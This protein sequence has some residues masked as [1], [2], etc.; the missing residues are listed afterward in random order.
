M[1]QHRDAAQKAA[2]HRKLKFD[3]KMARVQNILESIQVITDL[4]CQ[5]S[6]LQQQC[7]SK[8]LNNC[9]KVS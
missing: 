4:A 5:L 6:F 1:Q 3:T 8:P 9:F 2:A 7:M